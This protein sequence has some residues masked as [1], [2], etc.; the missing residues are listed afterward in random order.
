MITL[1]IGKQRIELIPLESGE[2]V[3]SGIEIEKTHHDSEG[4]WIGLRKSL[5]DIALL[6][7]VKF[8]NIKVKDNDLEITI[9]PAEF[10]SKS[11]PME[12]PSKY[13]G[14]YQLYLY[15]ISDR[16]IENFKKKNAQKPN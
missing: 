16:I 2:E 9:P 3:W 5:L 11:K 15:P 13:S 8:L 4:S 10:V 1:A 7:K 14:T 12:M 6:R